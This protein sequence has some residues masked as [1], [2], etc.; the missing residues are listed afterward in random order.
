MALAYRDYRTA[1]REF[2]A[3]AKVSPNRWEWHLGDAWALEGLKKPKEAIAEYDRVM[4]IR[5]D[6]PDAV[7]GEALGYK[8][9][10]Q[11][12][13]AKELDSKVPRPAGRVAAAR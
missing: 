5:A 8:D 6:Q 4:A 7:Y 9:L 1:D 12:D 13:K 10:K 2:A 3:A 11:I